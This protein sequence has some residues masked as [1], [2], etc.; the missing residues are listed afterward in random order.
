[1][2]LAFEESIEKTFEAKGVKRISLIDES[3]NYRFTKREFE[4]V[5][6]LDS[7]ANYSLGY[8]IQNEMILPKL[9]I[10]GSRVQKR[11]IPYDIE[12]TKLRFVVDFVLDEYDNNGDAI[13]R[14]KDLYYY[15]NLAGET[16]PQT[17]G[18]A[19]YD[20]DMAFYYLVSF[21]DEDAGLTEEHINLKS[22]SD[23]YY[24]KGVLDLG[25]TGLGANPLNT[26]ILPGDVN[27]NS[28]D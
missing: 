18:N 21:A 9:D 17:Y 24:F 1:M 19:P 5:I 14:V 23:D 12:S 26:I 15:V 4:E 8:M 7:N 22:H 13:K 27:E 20:D 2:A 28:V 6:K 16:A 11:K 25:P 10:T 3:G